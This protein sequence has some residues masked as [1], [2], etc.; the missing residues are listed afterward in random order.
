MFEDQVTRHREIPY[1]RVPI[2][3][4]SHEPS[5]HRL[6]EG[7]LGDASPTEHRLVRQVASLKPSWDPLDDLGHASVRLKEDETFPV[8]QKV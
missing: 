6:R 3:G 8:G 2:K 1:D 5:L 4:Q 7:D